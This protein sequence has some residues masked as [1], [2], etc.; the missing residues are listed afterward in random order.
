MIEGQE[1]SHKTNE[2]NKFRLKWFFI[3][4]RTFTNFIAFIISLKSTG[5]LISVLLSGC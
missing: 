3:F 5:F 4:F 1:I 2:S